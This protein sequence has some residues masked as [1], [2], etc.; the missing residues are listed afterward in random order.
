MSWVVKNGEEKTSI[1]LY[2]DA[3][4]YSIIT[5]TTVGYGD[6]TPITMP[7]RIY[8]IFNAIISCGIFAYSV[9]TIGNIFSGLAEE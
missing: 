6:I 2:I 9:N 4:Y 5:C 3:L 7:E 1:N 8:G